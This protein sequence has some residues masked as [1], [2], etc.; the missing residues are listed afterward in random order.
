MSNK[1]DRFLCLTIKE[2]NGFS[3][4]DL[5]WAKRL[6]FEVF[7]S[8]YSGR[9]RLDETAQHMAEFLIDPAFLARKIDIPR[10]YC[11]DDCTS[12]D[13]HQVIF[14]TLSKSRYWEKER[15]A[16]YR[17]RMHE[18][19]VLDS[20]KNFLGID[21]CSGLIY[22]GSALRVLFGDDESI[23]F[24]GIQGMANALKTTAII[25][26]FG[27]QGYTAAGYNRIICSEIASDSI[28][29]LNELVPSHMRDVLLNPA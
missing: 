10:S 3:Q 27:D 15:F 29:K 22:D 26:H 8:N 23:S 4:D 5:A 2:A 28:A 20:V 25:V 18:R 7:V 14:N 17:A 12:H 11:D 16:R 13:A 1:N 21:E 6:G 24:S 19:E 9:H